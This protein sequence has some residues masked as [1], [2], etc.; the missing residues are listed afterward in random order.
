VL[1]VVRAHLHDTGGVRPAV[2][3]RMETRPDPALAT[4][5]RPPAEHSAHRLGCYAPTVRF[6]YYIVIFL[7]AFVAYAGCASHN[8]AAACGLATYTVYGCAD[9]AT[10]SCSDGTT[11]KLQPHPGACPALP[12]ATSIWTVSKPAGVTCT[13]TS[14]C[15]LG[16]DDEIVLEWLPNS[17]PEALPDG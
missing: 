6:A 1:D 10:A 8:P 5:K 14:M 4:M 9:S 2:V 17:S 7:G 12:P 13:I 3:V 11:Y 16:G 15:L